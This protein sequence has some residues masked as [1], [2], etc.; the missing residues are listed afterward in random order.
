MVKE[1]GNANP[2]NDELE[3]RNETAENID[4]LDDDAQDNNQEQ[5]H[6]NLY[7]EE[8]RKSLQYFLK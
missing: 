4:H 7:E 2:F 1:T 3:D 6:D 5:A 8:E